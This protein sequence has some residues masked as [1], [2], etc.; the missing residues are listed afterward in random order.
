MKKMML[1][2]STILNFSYQSEIRSN[3]SDNLKIEDIVLVRSQNRKLEQPFLKL[4]KNKRKF[5]GIIS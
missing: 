1:V 4:K 3:Q 2:S 5:T